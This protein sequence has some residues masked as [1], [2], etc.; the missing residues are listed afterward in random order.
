MQ[1]MVGPGSITQFAMSTPP[2]IGSLPADAADP[3][4]KLG[5]NVAATTFTLTA[6]VNSG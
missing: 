1:V 3:L 2:P 5:V 4:V 6:P